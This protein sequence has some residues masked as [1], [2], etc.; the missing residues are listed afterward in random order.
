MQAKGIRIRLRNRGSETG[1][2]TGPQASKGGDSPFYTAGADSSE[3]SVWKGRVNAQAVSTKKEQVHASSLLEQHGEVFQQWRVHPKY[4][5]W[6]CCR[7][8][9]NCALHPV[10][11]P[12]PM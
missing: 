6:V 11:Y 2:G 4:L 7:D 10:L 12:G 9:E 8:P 5:R 3:R 1:I